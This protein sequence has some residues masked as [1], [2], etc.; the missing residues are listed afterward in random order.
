MAFI[1]VL[2][3]SGVLFS[4]LSLST[5]ATECAD[6]DISA[7]LHLSPVTEQTLTPPSSADTDVSLQLHDGLLKP[8]LDLLL[9]EQFGVQAIEWRASTHH[10]WPTVYLLRGTS[11]RQLLQQ[12]LEPYQLR[13]TL[14]ANHTAVIDYQQSQRAAL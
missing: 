5:Q 14:H 8:Q 2:F 9:R 12:V 3:C 10:L 6:F 13:V 1:R 7:D 4:G 11:W